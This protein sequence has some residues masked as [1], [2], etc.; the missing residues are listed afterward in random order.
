MLERWL[1]D[2]VTDGP[3]TVRYH[4]VV[5]R[6]PDGSLAGARDCFVTL[7]GARC[8]VLLS[9]SLVEPPHRRSGLA[10]LLRTAPAAL[11]RRAVAHA[12]MPRE[13]PILLVAEM[14]PVDPAD[15][16]SLVR[17]LAYGRAGYV[18]VP[19][20]AMPYCQ[21]D[22]RD[23]DA[24][25]ED[26]RPIPMVLVARWLDHEGAA[27][28]AAHVEGIVR[29]FR[30]IHLRACRRADLDALLDRALATLAAWPLDPVPVLRLDGPPAETLA[31]LLKSRVLVHYPQAWRGD[32]PDGDADLAAL[33]AATAS[34]GPARGTLTPGG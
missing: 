24:L 16:G 15:P 6:A 13:T 19:P 4:L 3:I 14:E 31:P 20:A 2:P 5:A 9:H 28:P 26:Q 30:A 10:G 12:G 21:P 18:A 17:L 29:A 22:F 27:I 23:L 8:V 34:S 25:G 32:V 1:T 7:D 11:A 33:V